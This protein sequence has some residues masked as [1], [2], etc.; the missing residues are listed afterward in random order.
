MRTCEGVERGED[1]VAYIIEREG[2]GLMGFWE[3]GLF[4]VLLGYVNDDKLYDYCMAHMEIASKTV[5]GLSRV[6]V[7]TLTST[8]GKTIVLNGPLTPGR[9]SQIRQQREPWF[10]RD[11]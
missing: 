4:V 5:R 7:P 9:S 6:Y 11:V 1:V 2:R 8:D 10:Y 3:S